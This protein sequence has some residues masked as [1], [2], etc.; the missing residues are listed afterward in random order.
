M[1]KFD[2]SEFVLISDIE[3]AEIDYIMNDVQ[4]F[5]NCRQLI[6]EL[7]ATEYQGK[8]YTINDLKKLIVDRLGFTYTDHLDDV[9]IFS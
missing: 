6:V 5:K 2:V 8:K 1:K 7:H 9:Y 4:A 3:G